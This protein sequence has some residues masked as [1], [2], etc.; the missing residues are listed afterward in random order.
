MF[1]FSPMISS[2]RA[3]AGEMLKYK[4]EYKAHNPR[5][6]MPERRFAC[7]YS[8]VVGIGEV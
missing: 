3:N 7:R 6:G 2:V 4:T 8:R 1:M 5:K